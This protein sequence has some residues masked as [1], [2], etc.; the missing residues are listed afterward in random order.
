VSLEEIFNSAWDVVTFFDSLEHF[1]DPTI[2]SKINAK[3]I[4]ITVPDPTLVIDFK[5]W[6]HWKPGEHLYHFT[7]CS[8]RELFSGYN[9]VDSSFFEDIVRGKVLDKET[10]INNTMTYVFERKN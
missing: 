7:P 1:P 3:Y 9:L 5:N 2:F 10:E 4:V 6:K 8:L